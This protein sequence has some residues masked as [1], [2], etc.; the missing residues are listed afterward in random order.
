MTY[1]EFREFDDY[2]TSGFEYYSSV[3]IL[4]PNHATEKD[5]Q[6]YNCFKEIKE[7]LDR[8]KRVAIFDELEKQPTVSKE[9]FIGDVNKEWIK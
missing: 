6:K 5:I 4:Y 2:I 8:F 3:V 7:R 9:F 1:T